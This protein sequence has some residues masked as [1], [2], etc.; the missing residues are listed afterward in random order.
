MTFNQKYD[1]LNAKQRETWDKE[2]KLKN[3]GL[4]FTHFMKSNGCIYAGEALYKIRTVLERLKVKEIYVIDRH[5]SKRFLCGIALNGIFI[6][7]QHV[8]TLMTE[9]DTFAW[10][11][12][13]LPPGV[14]TPETS[15]S[16][17]PMFKCVDLLKY[18][19]DRKL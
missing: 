17:K 4:N 16:N 15:F 12:V 5:L 14:S 10:I 19:K 13:L 6:E 1:N 11:S 8:S 7:K 2:S 3:D 18:I 9:N